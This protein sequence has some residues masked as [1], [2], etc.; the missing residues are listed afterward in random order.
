MKYI[1][2]FACDFAQELQEKLDD[3]CK[4]H[5][6]IIVDQ[7]SSVSYYFDVTYGQSRTKYLLTVTFDNGELN[8]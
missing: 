3:Y 2:V 5:N 7:C 8:V 1:K 6:H 4:E